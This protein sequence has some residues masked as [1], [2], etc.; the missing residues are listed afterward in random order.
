[1]GVQTCALPISQGRGWSALPLV[2]RRVRPPCRWSGRRCR[3]GVRS[4]ETV[5][6][7]VTFGPVGRQNPAP[8]PHGHGYVGVEPARGPAGPYG[9]HGD[10]R[11]AGGRGSPPRSEE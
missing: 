5:E 7:P 8:I 3:G 9:P 11:R 2:R 10:R 4:A 1:T 6:R